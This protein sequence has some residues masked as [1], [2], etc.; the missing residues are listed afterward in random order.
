MI[1]ASS[2]AVPT[3]KV[4]LPPQSIRARRGARTSRRLR[5]DHTVPNRPNGTL[6]QNTARQS[7]SASR[8][9]ATRPRNC[10]ASAAIWLTPSAMPRCSRG[11]ASVRIAAEFAVSMDPPTACTI[12]Q[13]ISHSA[14][15]PAWNGSND[16]AT[17][18]ALK[19]TKPM[20]YI[21][22]RPNMSPSRPSVTTSTA[23]TSR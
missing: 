2:D 23:E 15:A 19:I 10:P 16:S 8:P 1:A 22:T 3:A 7:I 21:R 4:M 12:R 20:L 5:I 9:P 18:A 17:E 11:K 14:P 6:T 13:P